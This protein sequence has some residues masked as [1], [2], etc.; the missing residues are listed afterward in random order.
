MTAPPDTGSDAGSDV[1]ASEDVAVDAPPT[2]APTG[3]VGGDGGGRGCVL[4]PGRLQFRSRHFLATTP[5]YSFASA[6]TVIVS[7]QHYE[8]VLA[9]P[10]S[11][12]S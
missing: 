4:H 2:D 1:T 5:T 7:T 8:A 9:S 6:T 12:A 11:G 10:T 3:C